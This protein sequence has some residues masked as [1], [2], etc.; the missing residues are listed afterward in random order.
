MH[1]KTSGTPTSL[2]TMQLRSDTCA[3]GRKDDSA[4][5][6]LL[7]EDQKISSWA[8]QVQASSKPMLILPLPSRNQSCTDSKCLMALQTTARATPFQLC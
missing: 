7:H 8:A 6:H 4:R 2:K 5:A 1:A 3:V